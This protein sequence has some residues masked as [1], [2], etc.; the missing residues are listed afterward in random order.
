MES[1]RD[2]EENGEISTINNSDQQ[3]IQLSNPNRPSSVITSS[4]GPKSITHSKQHCSTSKRVE[5]TIGLPDK[6]QQHQQQRH[7]V[8]SS[9][10]QPSCSSTSSYTRIYRPKSV[11]KRFNIDNHR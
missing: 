4:I 7:N 1:I 9:S 10:G 8:P 2:E 11:L 6:H 3:S 5:F